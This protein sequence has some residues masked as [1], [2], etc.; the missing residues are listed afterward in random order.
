MEIPAPTKKIVKFYRFFL[1]LTDSRFYSQQNPKISD[2]TDSTVG[3]STSG[4]VQTSWTASQGVVKLATTNI[5]KS[6]DKDHCLKLL[7]KF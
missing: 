4:I 5:E 7:K 2:S 6:S 3:K 1:C